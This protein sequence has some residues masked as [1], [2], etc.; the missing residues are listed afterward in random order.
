MSINSAKSVMQSGFVVWLVSLAGVS[1]AVIVS[2]PWLDRPVAL[3]A[4]GWFGNY[5]TV[6]HLGETT[7][8]FGHLVVL[9][10]A[11]LLA[12]WMLAR[13][14]G[15][16]DVASNLCIV[17]LAVA[18]PLRSWLKFIFGRTWPAYGRPSSFLRAPTGSIPS[19]VDLTLGHFPPGMPQ[20][21]APSP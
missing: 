18:G 13:R 17:T 3:L 1:A 9:G 19:T 16:I 10:F 14:F 15:M 5:R 2:V 8:F 7:D 6:Q 20:R 11:V 21:S 4:Y 12:R